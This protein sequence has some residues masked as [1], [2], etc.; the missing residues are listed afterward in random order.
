MATIS[1]LARSLAINTSIDIVERVTQLLRNVC[2]KTFDWVQDLHYD[3]IISPPNDN[4]DYQLLRDAAAICRSTFNVGPAII[5]KLLHSTQDIEI[6]LSCAFLI[7]A[8]L[9]ADFSEF[10][11]SLTH[12]EAIKDAIEGDESDL[13]I[14]LAIRKVWPGYRPCAR[15]WE[16]FPNPNSPWLVSTT[17]ETRNRPSQT[18]LI[19]LLD[20]CLLLDGKSIY[21]RLPYSILHHPTYHQVFGDRDFIVN[22]SDLPGMDF[23]TRIMTSDHYHDVHFSLRGDSDR[24]HIRAESNNGEILVLI[25]HDILENDLPPMLVAGYVHW[26]N[27]SMSIVEIRPLSRIWEQSSDDWIIHHMTGNYYRITKGLQSL[28]D[29]RSATWAMVSHPLRGLE[30]PAN[31]IVTASPRNA[32][33]SSSPCLRISVS[34]P[35]YGLSFF[36]NQNHELESDDFKNMVY[37]ENQSIGTLVGF[38]HRL[39]LR[40]SDQIAGDLTP[41]CILIPQGEG[42]LYLEKDGSRISVTI[43]GLQVKGGTDEPT[44]YNSYPQHLMAYHAYTIDTELGCLTGIA[45]QASRLY[46]A[47]LHAL[48]S[49]D[50]RPDPLTGRTGLEEAISL[51]WSTRRTGFDGYGPT[52]YTLDVESILEMPESPQLHFPFGPKYVD[53]SIDAM[54]QE[55]YLFPSDAVALRTRIPRPKCDQS[56][57]R[58]RWWTP[59]APTWEKDFAYVIAAAFWHWSSS[60]TGTCDISSWVEAWGD[61]S[62]FGATPVSHIYPRM[63][64][65]ISQI[66]A[67]LHNLFQSADVLL[68]LTLVAFAKQPHVRWEKQ[69]C[70]AEYMLLDGILPRSKSTDTE[71]TRDHLVVAASRDRNLKLKEH[72]TGILCGPGP[73]S[74]QVP[75]LVLHWCS[76]EPS[77]DWKVTM[78][79]LLRERLAPELPVP[80]SRL[81]C[82][83]PAHEVSLNSSSLHQLLAPLRQHVTTP[84]F[85]G[86]Y[87]S[88]LWDSVNHAHSGG[89]TVATTHGNRQKHLLRRSEITMYS[90]G[91]SIGKRLTLS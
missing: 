50:C 42:E 60:W 26:L 76:P 3:A 2:R 44:D 8:T 40:P 59:P 47:C 65:V 10:Y 69:L 30:I 17:G 5:N 87:L 58:Q 39:V 52:L 33:P 20:G 57:V 7:R 25:P 54:L 73:H 89:S 27:I 48:T 35:R 83:H 22:P 77:P 21:T 74:V 66:K 78:D 31:L 18:I 32:V 75:E 71:D 1:L 55:A 34:L 41:R 36:V 70:W 64:E 72:L 88:R 82:N 24:L 14:D 9:P 53:V 90:A 12:A 81:H 91:P 15:R 13:G 56:S 79:R 86:Q 37:D 19:H 43:P 67:E 51:V 28:V 62:V 38:V 46:L 85:Q 6:A 29:I 68:L 11:L 4:Q 23:S 49:S 16:S 61:E 45:N 63:I 80:N 84:T